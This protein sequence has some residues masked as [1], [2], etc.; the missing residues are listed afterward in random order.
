M[1]AMRVEIAHGFLPRAW[2]VFIGH[3]EHQID[4]CGDRASIPGLFLDRDRAN[5]ACGVV[6]RYPT[7]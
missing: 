5:A 4:E 7:G 3:G 6:A 2:R 1:G